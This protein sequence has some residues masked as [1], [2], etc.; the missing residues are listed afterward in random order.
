MLEGSAVE[1]RF[2]IPARAE[3]MIRG[4]FFSFD[5]TGYHGDTIAGRA[6]MSERV[7]RRNEVAIVIHESS[8]GVIVE[9]A[10]NDRG[11]LRSSMTW[12]PQILL[13]VPHGVSVAVTAAGDLILQNLQAPSA[14]L[15]TFEGD[16]TVRDVTAELYTTNAAGT[17]RV[18]DTVGRKWLLSSDGDIAVDGGAG[19]MRVQTLTGQVSLR[20][21]AGDVVTNVPPEALRIEALDGTVT[22]EPSPVTGARDADDG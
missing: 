19:A 22:Q 18:F 3:L 9:V 8:D 14:D 13:R 10:T 15:Y 2:E 21:V 6:V 7:Q 1:E 5:I 11:V 17:T 16:I 12:Y 20:G 4:S